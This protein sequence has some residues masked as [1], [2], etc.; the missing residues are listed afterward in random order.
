MKKLT[1][2]EL[3]EK[4][5]CGEDSFTQFKESRIHTNSLS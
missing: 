3:L 5:S 4:I 1:K 2:S